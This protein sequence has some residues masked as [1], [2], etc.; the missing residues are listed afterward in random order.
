MSSIPTST[1]QK[2]EI[3]LKENSKEEVSKEVLDHSRTLIPQDELTTLYK[4]TVRKMDLGLALLFIIGFCFAYDSSTNF[5]QI[6]S[7]FNI[8]IAFIYFYLLI[9]RIHDSHEVVFQNKEE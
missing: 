8:A 9:F 4:S 5:M 3:D 2:E 1:E 7:I 6:W